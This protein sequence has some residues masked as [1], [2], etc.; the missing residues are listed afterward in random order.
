[1]ASTEKVSLSLDSGALLLAR[2]AAEL[3]GIALSTWVSRTIRRHAWDSERPALSADQ[4][5]QVDALL[6]EQDEREEDDRAGG[7]RAA[8]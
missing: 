1:M 6:V 2:R 5:A 4:Q 8:G 3:D 7:R